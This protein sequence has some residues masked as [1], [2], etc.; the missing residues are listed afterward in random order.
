MNQS[1]SE[2]EVFHRLGTTLPKSES[3][4][5]AY[6]TNQIDRLAEKL[7]RNSDT[8]R[9]ARCM[10]MLLTQQEL[11]I[12]CNQIRAIQGP[13]D[14]TMGVFGRSHLIRLLTIQPKE[15]RES[16]FQK[17]LRGGWTLSRLN[18]EIRKKFGARK[19]GGR[20]K[21]VA[22][23]LPTLLLQIEK[24]CL[25]WC[26]WTSESSK[27][28]DPV[29][30]QCVRFVDLPENLQEIIKKITRLMGL[31][32]FEVDAELTKKNRGRLTRR[33]RNASE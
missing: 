32:Q 1:I 18:L 24:I 33:V 17:A 11:E 31:L 9:K 13:Q 16:Y 19:R 29:N 3:R 10:A 28:A 7:D 2:I 15:K 5:Q 14:S 23:D 27:P 20:R 4:K 8:L 12:I 21:Q 22:R 6:G 30:Q 26:R 25:T